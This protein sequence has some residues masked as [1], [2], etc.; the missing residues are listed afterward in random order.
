M[1]DTPQRTAVRE[2]GGGRFLVF[3]SA[4]YPTF[5]SRAKKYALLRVNKSTLTVTLHLLLLY[6][7]DVERMSTLNPG[8]G[9]NFEVEPFRHCCPTQ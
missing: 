6:T 2:R 8:A 1:R 3:Y 5:Q 4:I 7:V 9:K